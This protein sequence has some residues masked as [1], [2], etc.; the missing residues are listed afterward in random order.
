MNKELKKYIEDNLEIYKPKRE[1]LFARFKSIIFEEDTPVIEKSASMSN[2]KLDDY[3]E[4]NN[5]SKNFQDTLFKLID[6]R[7]LIDSD[8]YNKVHIDRRLFSK[9]RNNKNYHPSKETIILLGLSLELNENELETLLNSASY[10]L[11]KNNYFD[12]I[13]RF[14]FMKGIYK[15]SEINNLLDEYNCKQFNY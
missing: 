9:I 3:I 7:N 6:E 14:C 13:I 15:I 4:I 8:V 2:I 11:P 5:N 10:S 12:L 1:P